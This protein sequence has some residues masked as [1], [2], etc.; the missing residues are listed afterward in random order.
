MSIDFAAIKER[1]RLRQVAVRTGY[2]PPA[3][4]HV[5]INCPMPNHNDS[6]PSMLL[7][8]DEGRYHC[9]G[10][11]ASGDVIQWVRDI[12][13]VDAR[14]AV[15]LLEHAS[16]RLPDP[17]EACGASPHGSPRTLP[18][19]EQPD[20]GRTSAD[21]VLDALAA[22]WRYYTLP[23]LEDKAQLYLRG[24]GIDAERLGHVAGHTPYRPD[25]LVSYL[26]G[27]GFTG[28][29][30]IDAGLARRRER[31]RTPH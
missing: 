10:C 3:R 16:A 1:H 31:R 6:T 29:E 21:R 27:H 25:Q 20:L 8:L 13:G 12:W 14:A 18:R 4:G 23:R 28:D 7:H 2:E 11:G 30:L 5:F 26:Q 19:G 24:R 9:F 15:Q 22:A 17:P